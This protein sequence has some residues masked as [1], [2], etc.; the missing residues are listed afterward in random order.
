[1]P[2]VQAQLNTAEA[3]I[4]KYDSGGA[5]GVGSLN[6]PHL[7]P[8]TAIQR[9]HASHDHCSGFLRPTSCC[10]SFDCISAA[11]ALLVAILE[12]QPQ[13]SNGGRHLG[14]RVRQR[15]NSHVIWKRISERGTA[16]DHKSLPCRCNWGDIV[17]LMMRWCAVQPLCPLVST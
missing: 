10:S 1:M 2:L 3:A 13:R 9:N 17:A 5:V 14:S 8:K 7:S 6:L 12:R 4:S 15:R 11:R 16:V